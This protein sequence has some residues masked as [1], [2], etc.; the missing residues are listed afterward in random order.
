MG[1]PILICRGDEGFKKHVE[2][3]I[4]ETP[5]LLSL[6]YDG[7]GHLLLMIARNNYTVSLV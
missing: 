2:I 4:K 1:P 3:D 6:S 7:I 5:F